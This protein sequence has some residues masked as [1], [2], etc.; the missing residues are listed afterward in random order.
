[1]IE[2]KIREIKKLTDEKLI[3]VRKVVEADRTGYC[4]MLPPSVYHVPESDKIQKKILDKRLWGGKLRK[5]GEGV[6]E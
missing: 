3:G 2:I 6:I 5:T 1:L 4:K